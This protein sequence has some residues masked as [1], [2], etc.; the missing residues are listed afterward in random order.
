M[1]LFLLIAVM[2]TPCAR[3]Q[4]GPRSTPRISQCLPPGIRRG[5]KEI[6]EIRGTNLGRIERVELEGSGIPTHILRATSQSVTIEASASTSARPGIRELRLAGPDGISNLLLLCVDDLSQVSEHEPNDS[7]DNATALPV[8]SAGVGVLDMADID[9]FRVAGVGGQRVTIEL[10]ARRLGVP[11]T[12]VV[13]VSSSQHQAIGQFRE[14]P[15]M[16]GDCRFSVVMPSVGT[17]IVQVKDSLYQGGNGLA[18]RLRASLEPYATAIFPLGGLAGGQV[19]LHISGGSLHRPLSCLCRLPDNLGSF[20]KMDSCQD[21]RSLMPPAT[22][23]VI[24]SGAERTETNP[25]DGRKVM[26][27]LM[28]GESM[29]GRLDRPGEIDHYRIV[30]GDELVVLRI[31]AAQCG[32]RLDSVIRVRDASGMVVAENDD[33]AGGSV[34]AET[35]TNPDSRLELPASLRGDFTVE[36]SD[37]YGR[38]GLEY[39]YRLSMGSAP[40]DFRLEIDSY[41]DGA[42]PDDL[43]SKGDPPIGVLDLRTGSESR[44]TVKVKRE[45]LT[46]PI[47]LSLQGLPEEFVCEP[48][49]LRRFRPVAGSTV[50]MGEAVLKVQAAPTLRE[51]QGRFTIIGTATLEDGRT[52]SRSGECRLPVGNVATTETLRP[53]SRRVT[54]LLFRVY[55]EKE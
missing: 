16:E 40:P 35:T 21:T 50:T 17:C 20:L 28:L 26:E 14:T 41:G 15:G 29:N 34:D 19:D 48:V 22:R 23:L 55:T 3:S 45:G 33:S 47:R 24:R 36:V 44:I 54:S 31:V 7:G 12:P 43:S 18:Y 25:T 32:S 46:G 51:R 13:T 42:A 4:S 39:G 27:L 53:V 8:G 5:G 6:W 9:H 1:A 52:I 37:R 2:P 10:E 11:I 38:G 49:M 30:A